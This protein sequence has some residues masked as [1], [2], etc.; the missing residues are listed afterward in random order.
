MAFA[1]HGEGWHGSLRSV[2]ILGGTETD[3][4][5]LSNIQNIREKKIKLTSCD[6][7]A[8]NESV[9]GVTRVALAKRSVASY[10]AWCM[11][12]TDPRTRVPTLLI[13]TGQVTRTLGIYNTFWFALNVGVSYIVSPTPAG[14]CTIPFCAVCVNATRAWVARLY[15]FDWFTRC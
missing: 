11:S 4:M 10:C 1:P 7:L 9:P 14:G 2:D 6:F 5:H 12:P 8:C 15:D 3:N 13:Y